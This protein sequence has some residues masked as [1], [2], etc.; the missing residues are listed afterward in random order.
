MSDK[1]RTYGQFETPPDVAD[2][3][4]GFCL[5]RPQDRLLDP[6]CGTG[7]FLIRA[8]QMQRWLA[9]GMALPDTLWGVELDALA[10]ATAQEKLPQA[11]IINRNFFLLAPP[12]DNEQVTDEQ[13]SKKEEVD[14]RPL[15]LFDGLVGN[16][17]YTRAEWIGRI[18]DDEQMGQQ[19]SMFDSLPADQTAPDNKRWHPILSRRAGLYAYFFIHGTAFLREGGRFGFVVPNSWLDIAYGERLKRYLLD[20]YKILAIIESSRE[21]WFAD[22]KVNTC[23]VVLEKCSDAADRAVNRVRLVRLLRPLDQLLPFPAGDAQRLSELERLITRLLPAQ[24][25]VREDLAIRVSS[26]HEL[27]A[28]D[29]W[30]VLLRAPNVYLRHTAE[31]KLVPLGEWTSV[32]RGY[33]TG[34]NSF[35][36]LDKEMVDQWQIE[37]RFLRPLLKS[38]RYADKRRVTEADSRLKVLAVPKFS[39]LIGTAAAD[40]IAWGESQGINNRRTCAARDPWYGLPASSE[41]HL[42]LP[43]G[44]WKRHFAPLLNGE[45]AVDQQI[46]AVHLADGV[47][48]MVA[49]AL[50]NSAWFFL[51]MELCGRINFGEGVL[52]LATYEL[53]EL[54]L[55]DPRYLPSEQQEALVAAFD[56]VLELPVGDIQ[57][58][59]ADPRWIAFNMLACAIMGFSAVEATAINEALLERVNTRRLKAAA[60]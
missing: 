13:V 50:L 35:F 45:V 22:A 38:L 57:S 59:L 33:T 41:A 23:L 2:L 29:R 27:R 48:P 26:Q 58:E 18:R 40:Y 37:R 47:D 36:Y 42:L 14:G 43:K 32:R 20:H 51:Q 31:S 3:L 54:R 24:D 28:R 17:P 5:R 53:G 7:A 8:E 10:A 9:P 56:P 34:A 21:R 44:I 55:P 1:Q 52:W 19:L 49:A 4:L 11:K 12:I 15:G 30:G 46:Y 25:V 6:S 39:E 60:Y 16:P